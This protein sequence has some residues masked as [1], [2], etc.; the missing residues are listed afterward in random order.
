MTD[1]SQAMQSFQQALRRGEIQLQPGV[2]DRNIY[3]YVDH[4]NGGSRLTYV[5]LEG[6]TVTAFVEF[7]QG[8]AIDGTVC[9]ARGYAEPEA[10]RNQGRAKDAIRV[11]LSE[12][13]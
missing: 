5:R 7:A 13:Q 3:V 10:Y 8:E 1:P 12:M 4:P 2:L 11:A 9:F 6:K